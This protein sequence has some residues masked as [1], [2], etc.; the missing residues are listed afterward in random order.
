MKFTKSKYF[1]IYVNLIIFC[2][3]IL[4]TIKEVVYK[5]PD[6]HNPTYSILN[7]FLYMLIH[8][9]VLF[10]LV[11]VYSLKS[12]EEKAKQYALSMLFVLIIGL[13]VCLNFD[14]MIGK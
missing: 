2:L 9:I 5:H 10:I 13:P 7:I 1:I 14:K 12:N 8:L 11:T 4:Q 6:D 3:Y